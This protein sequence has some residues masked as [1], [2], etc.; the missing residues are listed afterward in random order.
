LLEADFLDESMTSPE[1]ERQLPE[2]NLVGMEQQTLI[3]QLLLMLPPAQRELLVLRYFLDWKIKQIGA[4]L[5]IPENTVSVS[6]RRS[7]KKIRT[8]WPV[9]KEMTL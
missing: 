4:Y 5:D 7:L 2:H 9:N 6:I 3:F 1:M 8:Q